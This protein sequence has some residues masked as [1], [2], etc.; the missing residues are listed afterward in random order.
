MNWRRGVLL[1]GIHLTVAA[2]LIIQIEKCEDAYLNN[3]F[4]VVRIADDASTKTPAMEGFRVVSID[5]CATIFDYALPERI[6]VS[7]NLLIIPP[8]GWRQACHARWSLA[9]MLKVDYLQAPSPSSIAARRHVDWGFSLLVMVQ[10]ILVGGFPLIRPR[11]WWLE[12]GAFITCCTAIGFVFVL[13]RP[14]Q[15]LGMLPSLL[16]AL[17]WLWWLGLLAWK[18]VRFGWGQWKRNRSSSSGC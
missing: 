15:E 12:P 8:S 6:V 11:R 9:G 16:A 4:R 1:A 14:I 5:P 17:A 7:E 18:S 10:W 3:Q 2:L 13:I